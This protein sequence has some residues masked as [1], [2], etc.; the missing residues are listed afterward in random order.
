MP[1]ERNERIM[2]NV[3]RCVSRIMTF[4]NIKGKLNALCHELNHGV[5][6]FVTKFP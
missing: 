2:T 3:T 4:M 1:I 5:R 6:N